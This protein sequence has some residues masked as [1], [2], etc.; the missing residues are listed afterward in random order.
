MIR[1]HARIS[2]GDGVVVHPG[3]IISVVT[4]HEGISY[5]ASLTIGNGVRI[6]CDLV[7]SCCGEIR[8]GDYV[9]AADRVFI[10]D[11]FHRYRDATRPILHQALED[12]RPVTIEAGAF[13][14]VNSAILPGV[15]VGEGAFVAANAVVAKDVPPRS[16]VAGNPAAIVRQWDGRAWVEGDPR[17]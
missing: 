6:G 11:T 15:T 8:L 3:A 10:G 1:G 16:L 9:L 17:D 14:G 12:P 13:L 5:D 7:I 2:L 4:E